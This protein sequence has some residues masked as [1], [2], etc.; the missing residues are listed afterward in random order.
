MARS[1]NRA[2]LLGHLG[3][4]PE[5]RTTPQGSSVCSFSVATTDSF[6][7]KN[8]EWQE[9]TEWHNVV[10]WDWLANNTAETLRK[11]SKVYIEGKIKH[12][13]YEGKDGVTRYI[14][15]VLAQTVISMAGKDSSGG[16]GGGYSGGGSS[17]YSSEPSQSYSSPDVDSTLS[18]DVPF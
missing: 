18:D 8:G 16:G 13:S 6:K 2:T 14:T 5:L 4:D 7:D 9:S 3:K 1:I 17:N 12:R 11:G 10:C 15:E